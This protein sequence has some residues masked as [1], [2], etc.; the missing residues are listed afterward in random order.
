[1]KRGYFRVTAATFGVFT[2]GTTLFS[3]TSCTPVNTTQNQVEAQQTQTLKITGSGSIYPAL[4]IL[5]TVYE[6]KTKSTKVI[7]LPNNQSE[8]GIAGVKNNLV[9]IGAVTRPLKPEEDNRQ[10]K[11][12]EIATDALLVAT[13]P[14]VKG[15]TNLQTKDLKAIYSGEIS[16]WRDLGGPDAAIV[17]LDRPED[18]SAKKLLRKYYLGKDLK[19]TSKSVILQQEAELITALR[20]TPYSIGA[21]SLAYA[22]TNKLPANRLSLDGVAPTVANLQAGKYKM[23]RHL[24]IVFKSSPT[25]TSKGFI[26]FAL[27]QEGAQ[28]LLKFGF[29]PSTPKL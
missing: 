22:I 1:L 13:H 3:L 5:A 12:Q 25:E 28:E 10:I 23:M 17:V 18:E 24:G 21:F 26:D 29:V 2:V 9:E 14:T 19:T 4:K 16:N 27:S 7:F 6:T 20:D 8:G 11:Y 15:V